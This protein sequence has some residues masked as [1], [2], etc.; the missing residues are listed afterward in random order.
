VVINIVQAFRSEP[1]TLYGDASQTRSFGYVDDL[2]EGMIRLK[3]ASHCRPL[4]IGNPAEFLIRQLAELVHLRINQELS[5]NER[6]LP[7]DDPL[8]RQLVIDSGMA[9]LGLHPMVY[10]D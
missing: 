3:N 2:I 9:E 1:L 10:L 8:L 4:Q 7:T 5:L 6:H